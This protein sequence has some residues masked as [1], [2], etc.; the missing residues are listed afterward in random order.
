LHPG[1]I[2]NTDDGVDGQM[3]S[4]GTQF[5]AARGQLAVQPAPG[6]HQRAQSLGRQRLDI[7]TDSRPVFIGQRQNALGC[8]DRIRS[9]QENSWRALSETPEPGR[10]AVA[11]SEILI[12]K[13]GHELVLGIKRHFRHPGVVAADAINIDPTLL[14]Q[15]HKGALRGIADER[16]APDQGIIAQGHGQQGIGHGRQRPAVATE[17]LAVSTVPFTGD[18]ERTP[19]HVQAPCRHLVQ[20]Q[21]AGLVRGNV[22]GATQ[23]FDGG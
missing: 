5:V 8:E 1:R 14:R 9:F 23:R 19:H 15:R 20:G 12:A 18:A 11:L 2:N 7:L 10:R 22:C 6:D 17:D 16:A 4:R 3:V 21:C 13:G